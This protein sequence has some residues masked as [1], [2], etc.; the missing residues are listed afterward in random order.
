VTEKSNLLASAL[1]GRYTLERELGRGGMATVYLA[2]DLKHQRQV[3][4]KVLHPELAAVLGAERFTREIT[5]TAGLHHPHILPLLDSGTFTAPIDSAAL[6]PAR[7]TAQHLF[8]TMPYVQGE[9]LRD[10][11]KREKQLPVEEALR[12]TR[13][14]ADALDYA[15][16]QGIIHRDIKP[17]NI[18][19]EGGHALVADF[20]IARAVS[21]TESQKLTETGL[22]IGTPGYMS[23]EQATATKELDGRT[24]IYSLGCVLYEMLV[25]EVPFHGPTPQAILARKLNEPLPRISVV[26]EAVPAALEAVIAKALARVPADRYQTVAE[27][28]GTIEPE[29][30]AAFTPGARRSLTRR[31]VAPALAGAGLVVGL[32]VVLPRVL[33]RQTASPLDAPRAGA[34]GPLRGE[35][36]R[37]GARRRR[38][39]P[40]Y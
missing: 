16:R 20:G 30:L 3:A 8:Y 23:P 10:R 39:A 33:P 12:I 26:R 2:T 31:W 9:S 36:H 4:L 15:H 6:P 28:R 24:D 29:A 32:A 1:A 34:G 37:S 14:V 25:G 18:L 11:L 38:P 13:E 35:G 22:A 40:R 27:F 21:A 17:E 5:V 19:L 7:L